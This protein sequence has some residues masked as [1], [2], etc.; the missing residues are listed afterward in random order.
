MS[1]IS[2]DSQAVL[3]TS[4]G[5]F[6]QHLEQIHVLWHISRRDAPI[7]GSPRPALATVLPYRQPRSSGLLSL[8]AIGFG[9]CM[10]LLNSREVGALAKSQALSWSLAV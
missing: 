5:Y 8:S 10:W 1:L 9:S 4:I 7:L 6:D 2:T 3:Q